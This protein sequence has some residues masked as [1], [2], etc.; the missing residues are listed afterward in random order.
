MKIILFDGICNF[1]N[2]S[3]DFIIKHD[4]DKIFRFATLQS[5]KGKE[6]LLHHDRL[7]IKNRKSLQEKEAI[8]D[9]LDNQYKKDLHFSTLNALIFIDENDLLEGIE[10]AIEISK[11]LKRDALIYRL[12]RILPHKFTGAI[13]SCVAKNRYRWFG[14]RD[15][16]RVPEPDEMD[17]FLTL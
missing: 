2:S 9:R 7:D 16:C 12:L 5:E 3:V 14:K 13:Y 17:R 1:C 15:V 11:Y 8:Q 6:L 4:K 10:A